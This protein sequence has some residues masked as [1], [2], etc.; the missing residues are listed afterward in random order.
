MSTALTT[1]VLT[2]EEAKRITKGRTPLVPVEYETA[3]TALTECAHLDEAKYWDN[4]ADAL[5]AWAKIYHSDECARKAKMLKMHAYRR[6]GQLAGELR[7]KM[8][9][10]ILQEQGLSEP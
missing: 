5:A 4:K 9:V 8:P 3:I 1:K 2:K 10:R 7:P 6:M